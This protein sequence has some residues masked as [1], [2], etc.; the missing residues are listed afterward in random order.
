MAVKK[1]IGYLL[2][3]AAAGGII[4]SLAGL[5][6]IW[7]YKPVL[8][9]SVK[10]N[11]ALVDQS[12]GSTQEVLTIVDNMVQA[13]S[14][15]IASL[16]TTVES[17]AKT[18]QDVDP[19]LETLIQLTSQDFPNAITSTKSS[20][21]A[22]QGSALLIDNVLT[23]LT[24]IPLL[25]VT[26]Y[27]P[28]VPLHIALANVSSSMDTLLSSMS[29][30][31]TSLSDARENLANM[32]EGITSILDTTQTIVDTLDSAK[33]IISQYQTLL[34]EL[35]TKV[36]TAQINAPTWITAAA[37]ILSFLFLWLL[38]AQLG[39]G[40]QGI[41]LLRAHKQYNREKLTDS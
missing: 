13:P 3:L 34:T 8:T 39:L 12:L 29:G 22:A 36:E 33:E 15:D 10:E 25:T 28:D 38:I 32:D 23:A 41:D 40:L 4:F 19:A 37:V 7:S 27:Q 18:M 21:A 2:I 16:Q 9:R 6:F 20:L 26:P 14:I 35:T 31:T 17:V 24:S 30:I 1:F 5:V 11:L